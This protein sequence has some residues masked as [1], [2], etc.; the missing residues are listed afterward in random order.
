MSDLYPQ[1]TRGKHELEVDRTP[2]YITY[3][4]LLLRL[5]REM[6]AGRGDAEEAEAIRDAMDG[7]WYS[8][9]APQRDRL[10]GLSAALFMLEEEG[11]A[12]LNVVEAATYSHLQEMMR[13]AGEAA[14]ACMDSMEAKRLE[15]AA[16]EAKHGPDY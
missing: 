15:F 12:V 1:Q 3:R 11:W 13:K 6:E 14:V 4:D 7:S 2:E 8:L 10:K 5:A 9:T 16:E